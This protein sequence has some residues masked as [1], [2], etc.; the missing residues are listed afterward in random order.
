MR[1]DFYRSLAREIAE[2]F[3]FEC[4]RRQ[5]ARLSGIIDDFF[6]NGCFLLL[7]PIKVKGGIPSPIEKSEKYQHCSSAQQSASRPA[8]RLQTLRFCG[9]QAHATKIFVESPSFAKQCNDKQCPGGI[10]QNTGPS[11][12]CKRTVRQAN[13]MN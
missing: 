9:I 13:I 2:V 1:R 5:V 4:R 6:Q 10:S 12:H 8:A 7:V 11:N 3:H